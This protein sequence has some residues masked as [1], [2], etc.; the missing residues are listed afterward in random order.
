MQYFIFFVGI[1]WMVLNYKSKTPFFKCVKL[2]F[3]FSFIPFAFLLYL[4]FLSSDLQL[5]NIN[6]GLLYLSYVFLLFGI[7]RRQK[8]KFF[9]GI[10]IF[11]PCLLI[12]L[13]SLENFQTRTGFFI[14]KWDF[15]INS[16]IYIILLF[17]YFIAFLWRFLSPS[18][19]HMK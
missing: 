13:F 12:L 15:M 2:S 18:N 7:I 1:F 14:F 5:F 11:I 9:L 8:D 4:N 16:F 17:E 10:I 3:L 19:M 6:G